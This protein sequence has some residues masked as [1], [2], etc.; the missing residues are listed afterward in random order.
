MGGIASA[1]DAYEMILSGASL[2]QIYTGMIYEGPS[3]ASK[4]NKGLTELL[5]RDGFTSVRQAVGTN[6]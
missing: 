4:I 1:R 6:A 5:R 2:V 3:L